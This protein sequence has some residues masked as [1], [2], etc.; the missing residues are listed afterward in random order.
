MQEIFI[1]AKFPEYFDTTN[2]YRLT[3]PDEVKERDVY[4]AIED[5]REEF[6]TNDYDKPQDMMDVLLHTVAAHFGGKCSYVPTYDITVFDDY[7]EDE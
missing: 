2:V 4:D 7:E 6:N 1:L 5:L 3:F